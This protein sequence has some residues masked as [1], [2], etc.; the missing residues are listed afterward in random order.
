MK[1][2]LFFLIIAAPLA[3]Q[4]GKNV[5]LAWADPQVGV[6]W[7]IL[8]AEK[9]CADAA[10]GEF[11]TLNAAPITTRSYLDSN[12]PFGSHCYRIVAVAGGLQSPPSGPAQ[13]DV[14]PSAPSAP[15]IEIQVAVTVEPGGKIVAKVLV[16]GRAVL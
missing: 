8:R 10:M 2:L 16:N 6:T 9:P 13:A 7:S 12:V 3:A 15:T 4:S 1:H 14:A 5:A 11:Q